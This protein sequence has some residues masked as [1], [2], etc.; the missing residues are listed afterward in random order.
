[1]LEYMD[2]VLGRLFDYIG[3]SPLRDNTYV[4]IMGDNG[5]EL[6]NGE[7]ITEGNLEVREKITAENC[8]EGSRHDSLC[9]FAFLPCSAMAFF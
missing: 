4:M 7:I 2:D 1:M 6:F 9:R 3:S 5:S 8:N